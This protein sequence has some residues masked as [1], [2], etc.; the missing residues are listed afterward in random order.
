[1]GMTIAIDTTS[2]LKGNEHYKVDNEKKMI[3]VSKNDAIER[4]MQ[5]AVSAL[6]QV[7]LDNGNNKRPTEF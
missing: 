2:Q 4:Q 3:L 1:M 7:A 6:A 5:S